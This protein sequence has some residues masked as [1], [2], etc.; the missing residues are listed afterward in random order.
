MKRIRGATCEGN[1]DITIFHLKYCCFL[2]LRNS[3]VKLISLASRLL[4]SAAISLV[5][6]AQNHALSLHFCYLV[7]RAPIHICK[8]MYKPNLTLPLSASTGFYLSI[9]CAA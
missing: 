5:H 3:W 6:T 2:P 4:L 9:H 1:M 7:L 8:S